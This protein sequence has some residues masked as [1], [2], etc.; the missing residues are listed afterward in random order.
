MN[1]I[2]YMICG[3]LLLLATSFD[4]RAQNFSFSSGPIPMCDTS[5]FTAN[6]SGL[7]YLEPAG[8]SG[9]GFYLSSICMNITSN[10]PQTLSITLTS[11]AGISILLSAFN[12]AGG[13]NYTNTCF[14]SWWNNPITSGTAPFTGTW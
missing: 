5:Y 1:Q 9:W 2:R 8:L 13:S 3:L 14:S 6:V 7:G 12:G 11:P 4:S 10:H